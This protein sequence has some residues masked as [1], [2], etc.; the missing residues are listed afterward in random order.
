MLRLDFQD[1]LQ[2]S[3]KIEQNNYFNP[4]LTNSSKLKSKNENELVAYCIA[5]WSEGNWNY[6]I[7][8]QNDQIKTKLKQSEQQT[9]YKCIVITET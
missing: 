2:Q 4:L 9:N 7:V 8:K 3:N 6:L 1:C 5:H